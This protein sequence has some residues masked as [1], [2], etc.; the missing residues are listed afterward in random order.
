ME[1]NKLND[2]P[3]APESLP[4]LINKLCDQ[5][6]ELDDVT[7]RSKLIQSMAAVLKVSKQL[8]QNTGKAPRRKGHSSHM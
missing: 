7:K 8:G 5:Y 6:D 1:C 3:S 2:Q 4:R